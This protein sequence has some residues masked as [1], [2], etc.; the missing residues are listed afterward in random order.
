MNDEWM[1]TDE[2]AQALRVT[3]QTITRWIREGKLAAV[4][5]QTSSRPIY[6][7]RRSAFRDFVRRYVR[8]E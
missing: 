7:V 4:V 6:R 1:T 8:G 5:I 2:V 3:R